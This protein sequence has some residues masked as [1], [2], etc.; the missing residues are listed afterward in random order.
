MALL[1]LGAGQPD[2]AQAEPGQA[3]QAGPQRHALL[4]PRFRHHAAGRHDALPQGLHL[5]SADLCVTSAAPR[6]RLSTR[7]GMGNPHRPPNG[8]HS[9]DRRRCADA[10]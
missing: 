6:D 2:P 5:Q 9:A 8:L 1:S 3:T 4:Y 7:S 10:G